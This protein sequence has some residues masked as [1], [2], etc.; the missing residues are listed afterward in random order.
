MNSLLKV[1][2]LDT[3][4]SSDMNK[5]YARADGFM[6]KLV[7]VHWIIVSTITAYLFD[8]YFLGF[9]GGGIL[10]G[11]TYF[12]YKSFAG[13]QTY[14]YV[15][16]L[17][18]LTFSIIMIQQSLGRIE[19]HFH[20]FGALSFLVIYRDHKI[21][22]LASVFTILHHLIFNYL[23]QYNITVFDTPIVVFNYGCGFDIVLLH[24]AFVIFE[25]FVV[26]N[27]VFYMDK[28]HQELH[29]T[30]EALESV[31]KNLESMVEI[32][33]LELKQAKEEADSAN[34][35]KSEFLANMS[36]E[37]RTP[38]NAIIGFTDLLEKSVKDTTNQNYVKSVQD[39]SRI[40]LAIINDILDLSKVEAGRLEIQNIATDIRA[41]GDE[42]KNVFYH[43]AKSKAL[44]LNVKVDDGVPT[45]LMLDEVR[46]RQI[47]LNLI[48]NAIK[49]THEG[50]VNLNI[51]ASTNKDNNQVNLVFEVQDSG[52]GMDATEQEKMFEAFAQHTNQ[53][54]KEYGGTGLG[55]AITKQLVNL[56]GGDI[57][58]KS[59]KDSGSTFR[60]TLFNID[61][62]TTNPAAKLRLNQKVIFE[63]ATVLV[64]DD[65]KLNRKLIIEYLKDTPLTIIEAVNGQEAIDLVKERH[66]D[67]ILMD[68]KMPKKNG[69][70]ATNEIKKFKN[71]PIIAITASVIFNKHNKEHDIFDNFLHKPLKKDSLLI[72]MSDYLKSEI[73]VI[74]NDIITTY[75]HTTDISLDNYPA[76][77]ELLLEAKIAGDI[78]LIQKFADQLYVF[79]KKDN[80]ESF[81][82][83]SNKLSAA[84][85]SFDIGECEVLLNMFKN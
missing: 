68:I 29:R 85:E 63:K 41:I 4:F 10:F 13:T 73:Q 51:F 21:I 33:T 64:A 69:V 54:N 77:K 72:A 12:S 83:I 53:S 61:I 18:L 81:I 7:F 47:L 26:A 44:E 46:V 58:V 16:A 14:R 5:E 19:M 43:K 25:W 82:N 67:L 49:F 45:N 9:I 76:L 78:E 31:N 1:F 24:G 30:K 57:V 39:S 38:M 11:I 48:S 6:L 35:M 65:I 59:T 56:M 55:L 80:L 15:L 74:Q 17:V 71:I 50:Y 22:T 37:I 36:H 40:L 23:Q 32:R 62:A 8:A 52:I 27:I 42:I 20:I 70:E 75:T 34:N 28:T 79:A 84:V 2:F 3:T 66:I 60:I